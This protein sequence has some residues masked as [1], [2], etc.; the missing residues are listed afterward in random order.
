MK[1]C[2]TVPYY[3]K[4]FM[5]TPPLLCS[6]ILVLAFFLDDSCCWNLRWRPMSCPPCC[7]GNGPCTWD[8]NMCRARIHFWCCSNEVQLIDFIV[9]SIGSEKT[10]N[11]FCWASWNFAQPGSEDGVLTCAKLIC[12]IC[13]SWGSEFVKNC[14]TFGVKLYQNFCSINFDVDKCETSMM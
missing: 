12:R 10:K 1:F 7:S 4:N 14:R 3:K 11:K 13:S 6:L 2:E 9:F 8:S 5:E